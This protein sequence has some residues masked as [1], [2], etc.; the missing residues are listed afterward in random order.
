METAT[1]AASAKSRKPQFFVPGAQPRFNQL[2]NGFQAGVSELLNQGNAKLAKSRTTSTS[3]TTS[4]DR[5]EGT[6]R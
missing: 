5:G 6:D 4:N 2:E 1:T 3:D